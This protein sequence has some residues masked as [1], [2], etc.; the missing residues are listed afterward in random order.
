LPCLEIVLEMNERKGHRATT[1]QY[2]LPLFCVFSASLFCVP[3]EL[4]FRDEDKAGFISL[5]PLFSPLLSPLPSSFLLRL[6]FSSFLC[7][8]LLPLWSGLCLFFFFGVLSSIF[9]SFLQILIDVESLFHQMLKDNKLFGVYDRL[10][11]LKFYL[12]FY[13]KLIFFN[14]LIYLYQNIFLK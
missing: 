10:K 9:F 6:F 1:T 12:F 4:E 13:F 3:I 5:S 7:F 11:K 14:I 8:L 2:S